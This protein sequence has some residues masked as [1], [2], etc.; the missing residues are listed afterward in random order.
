MILKILEF[1]G[2]VIIVLLGGFIVAVL[3]KKI[4]QELR[5]WSVIHEYI[6]QNKILLV[7]IERRFFWWWCNTMARRTT[8]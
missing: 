5:K 6:Q 1:F 4:L 8:T 7:A 3:C 2:I